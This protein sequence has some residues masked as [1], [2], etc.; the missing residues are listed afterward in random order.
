MEVMNDGSRG[1]HEFRM[2]E[3]MCCSCS[4]TARDTGPGG[5]AQRLMV[6]KTEWQQALASLRMQVLPC[7]YGTLEPFAG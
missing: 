6:V 5:L 7:A 3:W 1:T 2:Q 4:K